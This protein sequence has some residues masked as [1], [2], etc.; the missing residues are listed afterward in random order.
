M[1][2]HDYVPIKFYLQNQTV[3]C[4]RFMGSIF[5]T[6]ALTCYSVVDRRPLSVSDEDS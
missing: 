5:L 6:P 3:G 1:C 2:G 4:I